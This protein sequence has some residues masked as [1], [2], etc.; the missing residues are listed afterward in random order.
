MLIW[1]YNVRP[2]RKSARFPTPWVELHIAYSF[3]SLS[4]AILKETVDV[5]SHIFVYPFNQKM[6]SFN[7]IRI[8]FESKV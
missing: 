3:N 1:A 6:K 2:Y 7:F 8:D 5:N 4:F